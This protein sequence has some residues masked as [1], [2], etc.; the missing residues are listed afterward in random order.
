[1]IA[2]DLLS[3][4][5]MMMTTYGTKNS[6]VDQSAC[7]IYKTNQQAPCNRAQDQKTRNLNLKLFLAGIPIEI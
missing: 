4:H 2:D 6:V 1:M 3:L 7:A 5:H